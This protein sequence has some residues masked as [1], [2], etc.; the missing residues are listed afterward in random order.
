MFLCVFCGCL[1][2]FVVFVFFR[3]FV[4]SWWVQLVDFGLGVTFSDDDEV[5]KDDVGSLYYVAPEVLGRNYTKVRA[6]LPF[7]SFFLLGLFCLRFFFGFCCC[8]SFLPPVCLQTKLSSISRHT[9]PWL[10][11]SFVR[12]VTAGASE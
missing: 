11:A 9:P 12:L 3:F 4:F 5:F 10:H 7:F 1:A 6:C 2:V 8:P